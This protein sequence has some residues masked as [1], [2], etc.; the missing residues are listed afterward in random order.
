MPK[1]VIRKIINLF[2]VI[3]LNLFSVLYLT[4]QDKDSIKIIV[5]E[6]NITKEI[7]SN[8]L[9]K[10][11][12]AFQYE[13]GYNFSGR[14]LVPIVFSL[15][16]HLT[17]KS[18]LRFSF[19]LNGTGRNHGKGKMHMG[20]NFNDTMYNNDHFNRFG[21]TIERYNVSL[22]YL[23]YPSP[24]SDVNLFFGIGPRFGFGA[25][26]FEYRP[27]TSQPDTLKH[28]YRN[29]S[30]SIGLSGLVG[31]EWFVARSISLFTEYN[32]TFSYQ[33]KDIWD[34]DYNSTFNSYTFMESKTNKFRFTDI[35]ARV[36]FSIYF[37]RPF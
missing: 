19:G 13:A 33:K 36:G 20:D 5:K 6:V 35:S 12:L 31:A 18:A 9:T 15:K 24:K 32:A 29:K 7:V 14:S 11:K 26:Y 28:K 34:A 27:S 21:R 10:Q 30:W 2:L 1:K 3:T 22:N 37:D 8:S 4:A 17:D 25:N 23:F 16:Y